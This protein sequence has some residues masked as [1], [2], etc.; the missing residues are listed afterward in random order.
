[1]NKQI[2]DN[3]DYIVKNFN[4]IIGNIIIDVADLYSVIRSNLTNLNEKSIK[5]IDPS[6][7]YYKN[8]EKLYNRKKVG[9]NKDLQA[10]KRMKDMATKNIP[11]V[12]K[13]SIEKRDAGFNFLYTGLLKANEIIACNDNL[14]SYLKG[15]NA[16]FD[17]KKEMNK[18]ESAYSKVLINTS[19]ASISMYEYRS[20]LD[21]AIS[22][23]IKEAAYRSN[24]PDGV[25][26][27][28]R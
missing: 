11:F 27:E 1:M 2:Y 12:Y 10:V 24:R 5:N 28:K 22:D 3:E 17:I 8:D 21:A 14:I 15:E 7:L 26:I 4:D 13:E 19:K 9:I 23:I 6:N 18:C 16:D 20:D 25:N